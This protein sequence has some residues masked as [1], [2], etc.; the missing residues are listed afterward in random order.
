M[1]HPL[2]LRAVGVVGRVE[3]PVLVD[4]PVREEDQ[5]VQGA[6]VLARVRP[7]QPISRPRQPA[8][9]LKVGVPDVL[10]MVELGVFLGLRQCL[11][12]HPPELLDVVPALAAR[13]ENRPQPFLQHFA[14]SLAE[15]RLCP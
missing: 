12:V 1:K 2:V 8:K 10:E 7:H 6:L 3:A 9:L 15:A 4:P 13:E 14:V 5:K 11:G